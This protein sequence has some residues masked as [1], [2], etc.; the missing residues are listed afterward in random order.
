M[1]SPSSYF[2]F[3][4]PALH[5]QCPGRFW[6]DLPYGSESQFNPLSAIANE[7]FDILQLEG[8]GNG[9]DSVVDPSQAR[10]LGSTLAHPLDAI[11]RAG[12]G[13]FVGTEI[14][15]TS[16]SPSR[17]AWI[18]NWQLHLVGGGIGNARMEDWYRAHGCESP[19]LP[20]LF[21]TYTGHLLNETVEIRGM[22]D[23]NPTDPVA[24]IYLFDAAGIALL[25]VPMIRSFF[26]EH[27]EVANWPLQPS[28]GVDRGT[29]ENAGQYYAVKAPLPLIDS[30]KLFYHFGLGNIGGLSRKVGA[31]DAISVGLGAYARRIESIDRTTNR[32]EMAPKLGVFWDRNNSLLG[33]IFWNGQSVNRV[34][35]QV[36][37]GVLPTGPIPL[38]A[39]L[40]FSDDGY[41][42]GGIVTVMGIG[43]GSS[44]D[45]VH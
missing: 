5:A 6:C 20:A 10:R 39:W 32:I 14:L 9:I 26:L 35:L 23:E 42:S 33:S 18:P 41:P 37:P 44:R 2:V 30:W 11:D 40:S 25:H 15:P 17:S 21:T 22:N 16:F 34:S 4:V 45:K 13:N 31:A 24:D 38:G 7:G 27:V 3:L 29:V 8:R 12:W 36:Y 1:V 19:F 28:L 43:V